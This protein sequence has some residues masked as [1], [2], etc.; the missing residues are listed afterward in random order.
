VKSSTEI[1][2]HLVELFRRDLVGPH[3]E[4]D[5]DLARER[6]SE[7]PSR[8]Y[9]TGFLAPSDDPLALDGA[10]GEDDP[11][12]QEEMETQAGEVD[13]DGAGGAAGDIEQP[14][15]PNTRRRFR[16]SSIGLTVLLD[17]DVS[18]IEAHVSWGDYLTE[19]PLAEEVLLPEPPKGGAEEE[20][21][22]KRID[23]PMVDWVRRP[24]SQSVRLTVRDGRADRVVVPESAAEQ[25]RGGGLT[26]ETHSRVFAYETPD[27]KSERVRA[28]TVFLVNRR[29][30]AHH[31]YSDVG[32]VFQARLELVCEQ[33]FRPRRDISGHGASDWD[34]RLG[35]LHYRDICE[36]AVGQN[37]AA[38][39]DAP[40]PPEGAVTRVW[41]DPLPCAEV[42]RVGQNEDTELASDSIWGSPR[43]AGDPSSFFC[44]R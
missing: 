38:G 14:E 2:A 11:S 17:P 9:L 22:S 7:S 26:L 36:W 10:D 1:R 19:P 27:G 43:R 24:R 42:E 21:S 16:P 15:T 3:P 25:R 32:Y 8:W 18:A 12:V 28:L 23:R 34:R 6:L 5:T 13:A 4:K 39:W 20:G 30:P 41:T 40:D 29:E 33:G 44:D 31:F 35:D 37:T